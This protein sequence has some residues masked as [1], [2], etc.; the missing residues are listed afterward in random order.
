MGDCGTP[1]GTINFQDGTSTIAGCGAIALAS[2]TATCTTRSL[3]RGTH[4]IRGFYAG[5]ATYGAGVAGPITQ[6][7]K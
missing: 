7:V 3:T 5:D 1:T 6:T 4:Q 2:G